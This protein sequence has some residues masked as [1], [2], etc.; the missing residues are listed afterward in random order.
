M[1]RLELDLNRDIYAET[2]LC[3]LSPDGKLLAFTRSPDLPVEIY[4][5]RDR[6]T[7]TI[8]SICDGQDHLLQLG[9]G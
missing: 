8:P 7:R 1:V 2:L 9:R 6:S 5:L 3:K 4:S